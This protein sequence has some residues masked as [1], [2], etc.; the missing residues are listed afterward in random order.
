MPDT[1]N[2][3]KLNYTTNKNYMTNDNIPPGDPEFHKWIAPFAAGVATNAAVWKLDPTIATDLTAVVT[4]W[5]TAYPAHTTAQRNSNGAAKTKNQARAAVV[6]IARPLIQQLQTN[7]L[8]TDTQRKQLKI[9][10]RTTTRTPVSVPTTSPTPSVDGS[11][12]LRQIISYTDSGSGSKRKPAGVAY[13][14]IWAK[15]GGP[16]PT[17]ESQLTYLGNAT[18]SPQIEEFTTAQAG[19][20]VWYWLRWVNTRGEFGPWSVQVSATIPG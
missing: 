11:Q 18:R 3:V 8:V 17:D 12:R 19:L 5:N 1:Q 16:A 13:C 14:E 9:N 6:T 2:A 20:T 4:A 10:V 7:P 15:V